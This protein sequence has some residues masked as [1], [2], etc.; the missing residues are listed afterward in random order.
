MDRT[1]VFGNAFS[2]L[3]HESWGTFERICSTFLSCDFPNIR[4][5]ANPSGDGGRDAE[6]FIS[7]SNSNVVFQYSVSKNWRSKILNTK[8][9]IEQTFPDRKIIIYLTNQKIGAGADTLKTELMNEGFLLD[10]RDYNWF[11]DKIYT[12]ELTQQKANELIA[13]YVKATSNAFLDQNNG[14]D[15]QN[16]ELF[17]TALYL[18]LQIEDATNNRNLLKLSFEALV[19][20]ALRNT[21]SEHRKKR[22]EI[23]TYIENILCSNDL[24]TIHMLIENAIKRLEKNKIRHW[25]KDDT[26]C[27]SHEEQLKISEGL[28]EKYDVDKNFQKIIEDITV[29]NNIVESKNIEKV[30]TIIKKSIWRLLYERGQDF[31]NGFSKFQNITNDAIKLKDIVK[32]EVIAS[33][34]TYK[35]IDTVDTIYNIIVHI[36]TNH[37]NIFNKYLRYIS[38]SYL[39]YLFLNKTENIKDITKKIFN[40]GNIWIDT[41]VILPLFSEKFEDDEDKKITTILK[42]CR[43]SGIKL[44]V[45]KGI[46]EEIYAHINKCIT[47]S[48]MTEWEGDIP[49]LYGKYI[50]K[51]FSPYSFKD[52]I[53]VFCGDIRP[54][55]DIELYL[56]ETFDIQVNTFSSA[57]TIND[58]IID[59]IN[60]I[61]E[62]AHQQRRENL[63][64]SVPEETI[65]KLIRHDQEMY[66][67]VLNL[68][69]TENKSFLGYENW[70]LTFDKTAWKIPK[71]VSEQFP[72]EKNNSPLIQFSFLENCMIFGKANTG[73]Q[74]FPIIFDFELTSDDV[75]NNEFLKIS[76]NIRDNAHGKPEFV[77]KRE[78]RDAIDKLKM[79]SCRVIYNENE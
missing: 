76:Q 10:I 73:D 70:L 31:I 16:K 75:A 65:E 17:T 68:R 28:A 15:I 13:D 7:D 12:N 74:S 37:T 1:T 77:I 51:G 35:N 33:I 38:N 39:L 8:K 62:A 43:A 34:F 29:K 44:F 55:D 6:F 40:K 64:Q 26:F 53:N 52:E 46:I 9:R 78:I 48:K 23:Y 21:D 42:Y 47:C 24:K 56:N 72:Q 49:F 5:M 54:L 59:A 41:S 60:K 71:K 2:L 25:K 50:E 22:G 30:I 61:W 4:T 11:L 79:S 57:T 36:L 14:F 69:S 27:I 19:R 63:R 32:R 3:D 66:I 18:G 58:N 45:T 20:S 67:G